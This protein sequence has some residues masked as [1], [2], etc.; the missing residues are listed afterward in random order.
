MTWS[1][2]A[3]LFDES[4]DASPDEEGSKTAE[5]VVLGLVFVVPWH[6]VELKGSGFGLGPRVRLSEV[7]ISAISLARSFIIYSGLVES[8]DKSDCD[9]VFVEELR[10]FC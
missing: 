6:F 10:R 2:K 8:L 3:I 9:L 7:A 4:E 5:E 1:I